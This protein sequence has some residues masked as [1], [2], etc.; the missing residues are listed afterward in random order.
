M[1]RKRNHYVFFLHGQRESGQI[2]IFSRFFSRLISFFAISFA[3]IAS[4][5][6]TRYNRENGIPIANVITS[7]TVGGTAMAYTLR[8]L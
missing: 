6:K 3:G 8:V 4:G 5:G 1:L 2:A 7:P